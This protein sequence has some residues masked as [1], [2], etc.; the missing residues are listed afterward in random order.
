MA[1]LD[2]SLYDFDVG[3]YEYC[4]GTWLPGKL[5]QECGAA[6]TR[7]AVDKALAVELQDTDVMFAAYP[8]TGRH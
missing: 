6:F 3:Y 2:Q 1:K 5:L 7:E 8:K 4:P